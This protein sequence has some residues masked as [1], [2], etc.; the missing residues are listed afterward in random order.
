MLVS[1]RA[2]MAAAAAIMPTPCH[3]ILEDSF[4]AMH[5]THHNHGGAE[6]SMPASTLCRPS[7]NNVRHRR[8]QSHELALQLL[9][10]GA[11]SCR[12]V[13]KTAQEHLAV[14]HKRGRFDGAF[15][16]QPP[17]PPPQ[18]QQQ[19]QRAHAV[20]K[21][22]Q[23]AAVAKTPPRQARPAAV[24]S[25]LSLVPAAKRKPAA[26][27]GR[28]PMATTDSPPASSP[29]SPASPPSASTQQDR[30]A[31]SARGAK[32]TT[33]AKRTPA[34][35]VDEAKIW[36]SGMAMPLPP[37]VAWSMMSDGTARGGQ[38]LQPRPN[39]FSPQD[40]AFIFKEVGGLEEKLPLRMKLSKHAG[41][42]ARSVPDRWHN[43]GGARGARDM[44]ISDTELV[45]RR[46]GSILQGGQIM[47]RYHEYCRVHVSSS[48]GGVDAAGKPCAQLQ[49][50]RSSMLYHVMPRRN[51]RGR[52][53]KSEVQAQSM[54]W[55]E[56]TAAD[57]AAAL[58][59]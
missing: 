58:A 6:N 19:Q 3:S 16:G 32:R 42:S 54:L 43:S 24:T 47:W 9:Y 52:P 10:L 18:L 48:T 26:S 53:A 21:S 40:G 15:A 41:R 39:Q 57:T 50:D 12:P 34:A 22:H 28:L 7:S 51:G 27:G 46:Y 8:T 36:P 44:K 25:V 13:A 56:L 14:V 45:R 17:P 20:P 4:T 2:S 38:S 49:E 31:A 23:H 5:L 35:A 37:S 30:E 1:P 55:A 11:S 59:G 33:V 29:S